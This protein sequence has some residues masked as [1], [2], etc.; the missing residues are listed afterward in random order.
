MPKQNSIIRITVNITASMTI[1]IMFLNSNNNNNNSNNNNNN[2][3]NFKR[4][5]FV[6][7]ISYFAS[8]SFQK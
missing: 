5:K 7:K 8:C 2:N 3:N 1:K 4:R 6:K